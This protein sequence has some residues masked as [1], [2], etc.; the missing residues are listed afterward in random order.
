[1]KTIS[2]DYDEYLRNIRDAKINGLKESKEKIS[3]VIQTLN[4]LRLSEDDFIRAKMT[5]SSILKE[6]E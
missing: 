5:L 2:M 6:L 3:Q 4:N 1:M